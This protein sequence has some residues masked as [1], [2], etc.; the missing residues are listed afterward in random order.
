MMFINDLQ[1]PSDT[2]INSVFNQQIL[3]LSNDILKLN[4]GNHLIL[5]KNVLRKINTVYRKDAYIVNA[6]LI[7]N[8][9][10][11]HIFTRY[12]CSDSA[13]VFMSI[14]GISEFTQACGGCEITSCRESFF[15]SLLNETSFRDD[16]DDIM[17]S[18]DTELEDIDNEGSALSFILNNLDCEVFSDD[19]FQY[20]GI[21][22]GIDSDYPHDGLYDAFIKRDIVRELASDNKLTESDLELTGLYRMLYEGIAD[23]VECA[24]ENISL[25]KQ[26]YLNN[27]SLDERSKFWLNNSVFSIKDARRNR[28]K[29]FPSNVKRV[30]EFTPNIL[31]FIVAIHR[32][33][34]ISLLFEIKEDKVIVH[35]VKSSVHNRDYFEKMIGTH[36]ST[37]LNGIKDLC[38]ITQ[39]TCVLIDMNELENMMICVKNKKESNLFY[40]DLIVSSLFSTGI[41]RRNI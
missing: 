30:T 7:L 16:C 26:P 25:L 32:L 4:S 21:A 37:I 36:K 23:S 41:M 33:P 11:Y 17:M 40:I 15:K 13:Y 20:T 35:N 27:L 18:V 1:Y 8:N 38:E 10:E 14:N 24:I 2:E 6:S 31:E 5:P 3:R 19:W 12:I 39:D 28:S 34:Y 29:I 9:S 22:N